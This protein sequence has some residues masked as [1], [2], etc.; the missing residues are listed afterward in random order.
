MNCLN[1]RILC[2]LG[3]ALMTLPALAQTPGKPPR[4]G[5]VLGG[6]G[7]RGLAHL[8]V[9]EELEKLRIPISCIAGTSAGALVGGSYATGQPLAEI[10]AKVEQTD[11][12]V[13]LTGSPDR[14]KLPFQAKINDY[15]NLSAITLGVDDGGVH[16]PRSVV[17]SQNIDRFLREL[18]QD[19]YLKSFQSLP[20]PFQAVATNLVSGD[21]KVF[22]SGDLATAMRA[23]MAVPGAFD[24]V[25]LDGQLYVDGMFVRNL[26]VEEIKGKCADIVIAVDV[27]TPTLK[28]NQIHSLLDIA[29]QAMNVA[30]GRN[31]IE[32]RKLLGPQDILITPDL[33]GYT[34]ASFAEAPKIIAQGRKLD[35]QTLARLRSLSVDI[36]SYASWQTGLGAYLASKPGG[37]DR[38]EIAA[39]GFVPIQQVRERIETPRPP[40]SQTELLERLDT[41]HATGDYDRINYFLRE[42]NGQRVATV[43]P[44]TRSVG[45]NYLRFG[46]EISFDTYRTSDIA[47]LANYQMTW[48]NEWGAQWRNDLRLGSGGRLSSE[49]YQ[50]LALSPWFIAPNI[51]IAYSEQPIYDT[52]GWR[53]WDIG[54]NSRE[55]GV[56]LG[57][58]LGRYGET[59]LGA[60]VRSVNSSVDTGVK[61]GTTGKVTDRGLRALFVADQLDNPR[62]PR[63]GYYFSTFYRFGDATGRASDRD[64]LEGRQRELTA[65]ADYAQTIGVTTWRGSLQYTT[66]QGVGLS[67]FGQLG[68]FL[69]LSGLQT[70][71]LLGQTSAFGRLMGYKQIAPFLPTLGSGTYLGTSLELGRVYKQVLNGESTPLIPSASLW[72]GVDTFMGP[73]Y[74]GAGWSNYKGA[75][76]GGYLYLGYAP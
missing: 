45:P 72:V 18:T 2:L 41:L 52:N 67:D 30:T 55:A 33:S 46:T 68:G 11:W 76:F 36:D 9:L 16:L 50:P 65:S 56:D 64:S 5:L 6:G 60:Y 74:L 39:S 31:V 53:L 58:S 24:L 51:R 34:P 63:N 37:Y 13:M 75:N 25:E 22:D 43:M 12:N 40:E 66:T 38:V 17:G 71:Q 1:R 7:A 3:A 44:L 23:S 19:I 21:I 14:R 70:N 61:A 8:G 59:R 20:I 48:L 69:Q 35:E 29:A 10:I 42:E 49:F 32:Q 47:L 28:A 54:A 4:V 27:G 62:F 73:L 15:K 26:P 57:Y